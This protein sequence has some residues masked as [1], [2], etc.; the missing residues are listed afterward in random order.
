MIREREKL[1]LYYDTKIDSLENIEV[2]LRTGITTLENRVDSLE[3]LK[4]KIY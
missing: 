3:R 2:I 4:L 1:I